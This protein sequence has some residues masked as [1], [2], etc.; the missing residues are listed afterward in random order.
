MTKTGL[1]KWWR[2]RINGWERRN[3]DAHTGDLALPG[4][5]ARAERWLRWHD[6]GFLRIFWSNQHEIAQGVFRSNQPDPKRLAALAAQGVRSIINLRGDNDGPQIRLELEA[7]RRLGMELHSVSL[8]ARRAPSRAR[9]LELIAVFR[10]VERPVLMHCKSG[11]DRAGLA[12]AIW[13]MV[14]EG[15][16]LAEARG[17]LSLRYIHLRWSRTGVLDAVLDA[18]HSRTA[19]APIRFEDWVAT[20]Y[21]AEAIEAAFGR[22]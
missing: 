5:R 8:N 16:P 20:E 6:H 12:S 14:I 13:L 19:R 1:H 17:M 18:Y 2:R 9:L 22:R 10:R 3:R 11:A 4:N 7:C 15:R 21:E